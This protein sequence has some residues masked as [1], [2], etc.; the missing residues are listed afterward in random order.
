M[1][2]FENPI[3]RMINK[4]I[5]LVLSS[6]GARGIAHIGVI[7]ELIRQGYQITSISGSSIGALVGGIYATG[8]LP[9]F[10]E[11]MRSLSKRDVLGLVDF[12]F[13]FSGII[14]GEKVLAEIKKMI[15]DRKIEK[16]KI[17]FVAVAT[18]VINEQEVIFDSGSLYN[19]IRA[20]IAIPTV[21]TPFNYKGKQ[22]VDGGVLNPIPID[23]IK[24][25]Q[26]DIL[27]VVDLASENSAESR[28][29]RKIKNRAR[30]HKYISKLEDKFNYYIP[31]IKEDNEDKLGYLDLLN[32]TTSLM[33][34]RISML[35]LEKYQPDILIKISKNAFGTY[36]FYKS[37]EII[38]LGVSETKKAI[39]IYKSKQKI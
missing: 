36:E 31:K 6:G 34:Q 8:Q 13:S 38:E 16:L 21:I 1:G 3:H 19:A 15:P 22:L 28:I 7:N 2:A 39:K 5:A 33:V 14:K 35:T 26:D 4:N 18:D 29:E 24:R 9:V 11:W 32:R 27:V 10:E 37:K 12:T 17:P 30:N 23:K 20:S 25:N